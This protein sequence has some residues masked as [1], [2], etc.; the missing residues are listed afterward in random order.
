MRKLGFNLLVVL[1]LAAV[2]TLLYWGHRS[3]LDLAKETHLGA[4]KE[5]LE[6]KAAQIQS[7][8]TQIYQGA[9]TMALLPGIRSIQGGNLPKDF[10]AHV[11]A[12]R[13][14]ED[15]QMTIQQIYNNLAANVSV[16]EV[17]CIL[18]GFRPDLGETPFFMY[19]TLIVQEASEAGSG[20]GAEEAAVDAGDVPVELEDEEYEYY[21][22]ELIEAEKN[23]PKFTFKTLD[24]VPLFT[25]GKVRT[26]DNTQYLSK[27]KGDARNA[28]GFMFS[29]PTYSKAGDLLGMISVIIRTNAFEAMLLNCPFIIV[30]DEDRRTA[31]E[32]GWTMPEVPSRFSFCG[33]SRGIEIFDRRNPD[34]L[35]VMAETEK[36]EGADGVLTHTMD[37]PF[38]DWELSCLPDAASLEARQSGLRKLFWMKIAGI[39]AAA[40]FFVFGVMRRRSHALAVRVREAVHALSDCAV[41]LGELAQQLNSNSIGLAEAAS[42]Q[43]ATAEETASTTEEMAAR[44]RESATKV[45]GAEAMMKENISKSESSLQA[46]AEMTREIAE[47][48]ADSGKVGKIIKTIDEI[49]FQTNLL[50]LN[51]AV[52]AA[53]AGEHGKGFA[54]V[55]DEVRNLARRAGEAAQSTQAILQAI[56]ERI[57]STAVSVKDINRNFEAIVASATQIGHTLEGIRAASEEVTAGVNQ[58]S[59]GA[60]QLS[61]IAQRVAASSQESAD[62]S[63]ELAQQSETMQGIVEQ[64]ETLVDGGK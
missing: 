21:V 36:R 20:T 63:E 33:E 8:L 29:V 45:S 7:A 54:V 60:S 42:A 38:Q 27:S 53:R 14:S 55:A 50:A 18:K 16:S 34:L 28:E 31:D 40:I 15:A 59:T 56:V 62:A 46:M 5:V 51:A 49:A 12:T 57:G 13:F 58:V 39:Y 43:S 22:R 2:T 41:S 1:V 35:Q 47:V 3:D 30:T 32:Q 4:E 48:E 6:S 19:D 10:G 26:C 37:A 61:E 24:E 11:D 64:L 17:Y 25:S 23:F 52:E 44:S 9:R